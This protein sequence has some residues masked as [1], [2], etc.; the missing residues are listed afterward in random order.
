MEPKP[1]PNET[2]P[3]DEEILK[4]MLVS[5][6]KDTASTDES[7]YWSSPDLKEIIR[8]RLLTDKGFPCWEVSYCYGMTHDGRRV[9]VRLPFNLL[10]RGSMWSD[11]KA[12]A[13]DDGV[14]V[15]ELNIWN[16]ISK[17]W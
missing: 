12:Y 7:V 1:Y 16:S 2:I 6:R 14:N 5:T 17:L 10:V 13:K 4:K 15:Q 8:L 9:S 3:I 11:I